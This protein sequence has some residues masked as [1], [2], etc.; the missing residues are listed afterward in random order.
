MDAV[1]LGGNDWFT[2]KG[3]R[4]VDGSLLQGIGFI[5]TVLGLLVFEREMISVG[6]F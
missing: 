1:V 6:L 2:L 3:K 5:S 4:H